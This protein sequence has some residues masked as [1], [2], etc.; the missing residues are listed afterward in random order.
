[1]LQPLFPTNQPVPPSPFQPVTA[2]CT[3]A[4]TNA[5]PDHYKH[6]CSSMCAQSA[7][8]PILPVLVANVTHPTPINPD[9]L[10]QALIGYDQ[11]E[12][13]FLLDGFIKG[14]RINYHGT[15]SLRFSDNHPSISH[16]TDI[17]ERKL[18]KERHMGRIAGPFVSPPFHNYQ[19]SPLGVVPKKE[20][21]EFRIIHYLSYPVGSSVNEYIPKEFTMVHYETLDHVISLLS[22]FGRGALIGK[23]DIEDAFRI[24]PIHPSCYHIFGFTWE[25][26]FYYDRCLPMGCTES[27]RIFERL[28]CALQWIVWRL[29]RFTYFGRFHFHW[30]SQFI[31]MLP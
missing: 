4:T 14:F 11:T 27:C 18:S 22:H 16:H 1:M 5:P 21:N 25:S 8:P 20:P 13:A 10:Q 26:Q 7:K 6:V 23:T 28:S 2:G 9:A 24:I 3:S 12:A 29:G 17:V 31:D 19:S 15:P 30:S